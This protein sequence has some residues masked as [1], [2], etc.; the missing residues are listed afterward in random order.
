[1]KSALTPGERLIKHSGANVQR[2]MEAVGGHLHL[3]SQRLVFESHAFNVQTGP[4]EI[5]LAD[6]QAVVPC[7]TRFLGL[8]PLFPNSLSVRTRQG[9]EHRFVV[10]GRGAWA[11]A[12]AAASRAA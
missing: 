6:I 1:M 3:T 9:A 12:I 2:G 7:W 4:T 5:A 11:D 10:H 8:I